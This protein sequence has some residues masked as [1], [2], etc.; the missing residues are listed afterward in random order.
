MVQMLLENPQLEL[1]SL[2]LL[3]KQ[4]LEQEFKFSSF[5]FLINIG[6]RDLLILVFLKMEK[7]FF[8]IVDQLVILSMVGIVIRWIG[9]WELKPMDLKLDLL[10]KGFYWLKCK[11][12]LEEP[13]N[14]RLLVKDL[15]ER[16]LLKIS[17]IITLI[18]QSKKRQILW[19][20]H[21]KSTEMITDPLKVIK[22]LKIDLWTL[23]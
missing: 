20:S 17:L 4:V 7:S 5:Q 15:Q 2:K 21:I 13:S 12:M 18:S 22:L 3:K 1:S 16:L 6:S 10:Q 23:L 8:G 11:F 19:K 9:L 14:V